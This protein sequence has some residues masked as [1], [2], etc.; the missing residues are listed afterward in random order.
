MPESEYGENYR[1]NM[2]NIKYKLIVTSGKGGVGKST[3]AV[4]LGYSLA[5]RGFATGLLDADI[6][7]P[8]IPKLLGI[9]NETL[10]TIENRLIP[11][12][13]NKNLHVVS[14]GFLIESPDNPIIWRG[15]LKMQLLSQFISLVNWGK[16]DYLIIDLPPGT[17]D[18]PLSIAQLIPDANGVVIVTTPQEVALVSVRKNINFARALNLP[19]IGIIENMSGFICPH[20]KKP[21]EIFKSGGAD[22]ASRDFKVPLLG[23]IMLDVN[24]VEHSERGKPFVANRNYEASKNFEKIVDK[25]I[26]Q[27]TNK[28]DNCKL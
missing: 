13:V 4:N 2:E 14:V 11:V 20:C 5:M 17:G 25:I 12:E 24:I 27:V 10:T 8:T 15:P 3:I 26:K 16:L 21:V 6:H 22:K 28:I 23:K 18:E 1:K 7:G 19:V 9:E